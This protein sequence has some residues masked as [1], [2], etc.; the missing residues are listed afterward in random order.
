VSLN[1]LNADSNKTPPVFVK[2]ENGAII[3]EPANREITVRDLLTHTSGI[4]YAGLAL[5]MSAMNSF[6][7][8]LDNQ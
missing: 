5:L 8:T 1:L 3:T 4:G 2:K 6:N 7:D